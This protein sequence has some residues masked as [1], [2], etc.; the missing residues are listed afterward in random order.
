M[1]THLTK[2]AKYDLYVLHI[3]YYDKLSSKVKADNPKM[4]KDEIARLDLAIDLHCAK[5]ER[6]VDSRWKKSSFSHEVYGTKPIS[7]CTTIAKKW[8]WASTK[9]GGNCIKRLT[10]A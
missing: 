2:E 9:S 10:Q 4:S 6:C 1:L 3:Q 8:T 5:Y 7:G